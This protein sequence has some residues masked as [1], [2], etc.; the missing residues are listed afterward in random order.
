M[1]FNRHMTTGSTPRGETIRV[2]LVDGT[3]QGLR[4][5]ERNGWTGS[6]LAFARADYIHAR[7]K[8]QLTRTGVYVLVGPDESGERRSDFT[9]V[10]VMTFVLVLIFTRGRKTSGPTAMS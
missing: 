9:L 5:V 1:V 6:C 2:Y 10:R 8:T 4:V 3:P 7:S